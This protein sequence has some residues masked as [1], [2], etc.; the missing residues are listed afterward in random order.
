M[1]NMSGV[2]AD[3]DFSNFSKILWIYIY[4]FSYLNVQKCKLISW[5]TINGWTNWNNGIS[6]EENIDII[7]SW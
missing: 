6:L 4:V 5:K 7:I 3:A 2:V 1:T